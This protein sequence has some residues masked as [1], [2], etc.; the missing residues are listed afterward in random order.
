MDGPKKRVEVHVAPFTDKVVIKTVRIRKR[1]KEAYVKMICDCLAE[2]PRMSKY[3]LWVE[4]RM[5]DLEDCLVETALKVE[6]RW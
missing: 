6:K 1:W 3:F 5:G 4:V 2:R